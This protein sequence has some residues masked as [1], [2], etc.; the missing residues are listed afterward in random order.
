MDRKEVYLKYSEL[1]TVLELIEILEKGKDHLL[2]VCYVLH[3][4]KNKY[5]QLFKEKEQEIKKLE[6]PL[7][8]TLN[9]EEN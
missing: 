8:R 4:D 3:N 7:Y 1:R 5:I 2:E 9:G 6:S